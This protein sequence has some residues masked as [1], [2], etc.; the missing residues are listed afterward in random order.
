MKK[1]YLLP[2]AVL[3]LACTNIPQQ[4]AVKTESVATEVSFPTHGQPDNTLSDQDIANG[5]TLL[6]DGTTTNGW[7]G[8]KLDTFPESGWIVE[9]GILKV[10]KSDGAES[11]NG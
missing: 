6:W 3:G 9:D 2:L 5:W 4:N 11:A 1:T 8:A 10:I 7:R